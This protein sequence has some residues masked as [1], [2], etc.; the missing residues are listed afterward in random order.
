MAALFDVELEQSAYGSALVANSPLRQLRESRGAGALPTSAPLT[1]SMPSSASASASACA[2]NSAKVADAGAARPRPGTLLSAH[3]AAGRERPAMQ[4]PTASASAAKLLRNAEA[5]AIEAASAPARSRLAVPPLLTTTCGSAEAECVSLESPAVA[6]AQSGKRKEALPAYLL[7]TALENLQSARTA[8]SL[9]GKRHNKM[10]ASASVASASVASASASASVAPSGLGCSACSSLTTTPRQSPRACEATAGDADR[11]RRTS[12]GEWLNAAAHD[13]GAA[14]KRDSEVAATSSAAVQEEMSESQHVVGFDL[15]RGQLC[16]TAAAAASSSASPGSS[17][18]IVGQELPALLKRMEAAVAEADAAEESRYASG[19]DG[20][21]GDSFEVEQ[22]LSATLQRMAVAVAHA[23]ASLWGSQRQQLPE[24][25]EEAVS[26]SAPEATAAAAAP[27]ALPARRAPP[28]LDHLAREREE[29]VVV[30][31]ELHVKPAAAAEKVPT[32][33]HGSLRSAG[34]ST[35]CSTRRPSESVSGVPAACLPGA[36]ARASKA[37][38]PEGDG[39]SSVGGRSAAASAAVRMP[40]L[41]AYFASRSSESQGDAVEGTQPA[42][43]SPSGLPDA[44]AAGLATSSGPGTVGSWSATPSM[45]TSARSAAANSVAFSATAPT[46]VPA[47]PATVTPR[48]P[49]KQKAMPA[50]AQ[51]PSPGSIVAA[52][53]AWANKD[54]D[55][56]SECSRRSFDEPEARRSQEE[57]G[58]GPRSQLGDDLRED[59]SEFGGED[60]RELAALEEDRGSRRGSL[61]SLAR[62]GSSSQLPQQQQQRRGSGLDG[63]P[64]R[65]DQRRPS[66]VWSSASASR[67]RVAGSEMADDD[68]GPAESIDGRRSVRSLSRIGTPMQRRLSDASGR[69]PRGDASS[70]RSERRRSSDAMSTTSSRR[71][72]STAHSEL[73]ECALC[74]HTAPGSEPGSTF[75]ADCDARM[76]LLGG[77]APAKSAKARS[78]QQQA[79]RRRSSQAASS[80]LSST[81]SSSASDSD[82]AGGA[83]RSSRVAISCCIRCGGKFAGGVGPSGNLLCPRCSGK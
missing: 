45:P 81:S 41:A 76:S 4:A 5:V 32:S 39:A 14:T 13:T 67:R 49:E 3:H 83:T 26:S 73:V 8:D 50:A 62:Y 55:T 6:P 78:Q 42:E 57:R 69:P 53:T 51:A 30:E 46:T 9:R 11:R 34:I 36:T 66:D 70:V 22:M 56:R 48:Q 71:R 35:S 24:E 33:P 37:D 63:R 60:L 15:S 23:D 58:R 52:A 7:E 19:A 64:P 72:G 74:G 54:K 68:H 31:E 65:Y 21:A 16:S 80:R 29:V 18:T 82:D 10:K 77:E 20:L 27:A 2:A 44:F 43:V 40:S 25:E 28:R 17:T 12:G 59:P 1:T 79:P 47:T 38:Q 61:S 75:C